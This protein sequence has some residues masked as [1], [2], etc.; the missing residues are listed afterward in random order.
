M[1]QSR[2][3][4]EEHQTP[5]TSADVRSVLGEIDDPKVLAILALKPTISDLETAS[6]AL[7]GD[8]DVYGAGPPLKGVAGEIVALL[9]ADEEEER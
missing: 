5:V 1:A 4:A 2:T 8:N 7:S 9:T 6:M 3:A